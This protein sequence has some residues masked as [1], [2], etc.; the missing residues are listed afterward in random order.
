[1]QTP[2][3][4]YLQSLNAFNQKALTSFSSPDRNQKLAGG[5]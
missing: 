1:M 3:C 5:D 4:V 2:H